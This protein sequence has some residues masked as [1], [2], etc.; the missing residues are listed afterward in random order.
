M[1]VQIH[2]VAPKF[3]SQKDLN[4]VDSSMKE[5][6]L[7][8][9]AQGLSYQS[10][11]DKLKCSKGL[12]A[13]HCGDGQKE[14]SRERLFTSRRR[15]KEYFVKKFGGKCCQC[16]YNKCIDAL[17]FHHTDKQNAVLNLYKY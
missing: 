7:A 14:K 17:E 5:K 6:I 16:G 9:R 10:I 15:R 11:V 13:Y 8:L 3:I 4:G 12:V 2:P 1:V